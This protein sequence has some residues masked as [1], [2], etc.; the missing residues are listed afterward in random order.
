M[1]DRVSVDL[2]VVAAPQFGF[3]AASWPLGGL[4]L[5]MVAMGAAVP[6]YAPALWKVALLFAGVGLA[7]VALAALVWRKTGQRGPVLVLREGSIGLPQLAAGKAPAPTRLRW[8]EV[9][10]L[11][12]TGPASGPE[13]LVLV[14]TPA[15]S[16]ARGVA[17]PTVPDD[18]PHLGNRIRLRLPLGGLSE[19]PRQIGE[20]VAMA[21][22]GAGMARDVADTGLARRLV[23]GTLGPGQHWGWPAES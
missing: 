2:D 22:E 21:A 17:V 12:L 23:D 5:A 6:F 20:S 9:E 16:R 3:R 1:A 13:A 19:T 18:Q 11:A 10:A 14:L 8:P 7:T 15:A 4:G